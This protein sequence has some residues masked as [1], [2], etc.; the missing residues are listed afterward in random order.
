MRTFEMTLLIELLKELF[1][2]KKW[3]NE[4]INTQ[5]EKNTQMRRKLVQTSNNNY[6]KVGGEVSSYSRPYQSKLHQYTQ[7]KKVENI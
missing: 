7:R 2:L 6:D 4:K 1:E 3:K 5:T